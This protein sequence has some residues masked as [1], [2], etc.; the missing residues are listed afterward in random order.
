MNTFT[1]K[2]TARSVDVTLE[3][4]TK[5]EE[6]IRAWIN[7]GDV[8]LGV[9]GGWVKYNGMAPPLFSSDLCYRVHQPRVPKLGEVWSDECCNPHLVC[10]N[11]G[12]AY[13]MR[14]TG[15]ASNATYKLNLFTF[16]S[17][18]VADYFLPE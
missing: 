8:D 12:R 5:H 13:F 7:G 10:E 6:A 9:S 4:L 3:Q 16:E 18:T 14:F 2:G 17:E 1:V 15:T 11:R